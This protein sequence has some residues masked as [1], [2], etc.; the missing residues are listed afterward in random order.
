VSEPDHQPGPAPKLNI[1]SID[2]ALRLLDRLRIV[3]TSQRFDADE[4]PVAP[5]GSQPIYAFW[6]FAFL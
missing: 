5:D 2:K 4:M 6:E 1:V 3:R